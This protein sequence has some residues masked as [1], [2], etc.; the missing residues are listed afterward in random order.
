MARTS[1][2][3]TLTREAA[4][5][6]ATQG[7]LPHTLTVDQIYEVI[8]QGSRTTINDELKRW[9]AERVQADALAETLPP[10]IADAMRALWA[11]AV[12][13][14]AG[15]FAA[16][17][18]GLIQDREAAIATCQQQAEAL[19]Q[20]QAQRDTL[21][22]QV[23]TLTTALDAAQQE[24]ARV[25][26]A[27]AAA[28]AEAATLRETLGQVRQQNVR[29]RAEARSTQEALVASHQAA[30]AERDQA[31]RQELDRATERLQQTE[32]RMLKQV[33]DART[34]ARRSEAQLTK[35]HEQN[36]NLRA[37]LA[38]LRQRAVRDQQDLV[39]AREAAAEAHTR[40]TD[41]ERLSA[42]R[43]RALI[44]STAQAEAA[45][46]V[47]GTLEA[48]LQ[49]GRRVRAQPPTSSPTTA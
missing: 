8:R 13:R 5:R 9:K 38:E 25:D 49:R 30:F 37:E 11:A 15:Q 47:I 22:E 1:D 28:T 31:F 12:E 41:A 24:L 21:S 34:A 29:E 43:E 33:D 2:T 7:R 27:R 39:A 35:A 36:A 19:S 40:Q 3:R 14:G 32:A 17:R 23:A 42:E 20:V 45:Q 48:A 16:E 46:R 18:D 10:A 4:A 26:A 6:L 44:T